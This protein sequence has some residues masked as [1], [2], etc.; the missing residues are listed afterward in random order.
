MRKLTIL[1]F[2]LVGL[3]LPVAART[4]VSVDASNAQAILAE[5][6]SGTEISE[7]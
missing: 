6:C 7:Q 4:E 5:I 2:T 1:G 3:S